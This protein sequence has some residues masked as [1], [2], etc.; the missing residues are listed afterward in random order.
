MEMF[1]EFGIYVV[2]FGLSFQRKGGWRY[3]YYVE[4]CEG[5][6]WVGYSSEVLR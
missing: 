6:E 4:V 5:D 1:G 3:F 2:K